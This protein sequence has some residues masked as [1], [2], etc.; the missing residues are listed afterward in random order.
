MADH[1]SLDRVIGWHLESGML[2]QIVELPN[3]ISTEVR[4]PQA[5]KELC[6]SGRSGD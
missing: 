4:I 2:G 5:Y 3:A 1:H 6:R